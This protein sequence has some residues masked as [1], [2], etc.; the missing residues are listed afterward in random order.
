[1]RMKVYKHFTINISIVSFSVGNPSGKDCLVLD[2][3]CRVFAK[4]GAR[5]TLIHKYEKCEVK[6]QQIKYF[7]IIWDLIF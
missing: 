1:M 6:Q 4:K 7:I 2:I 3:L 5:N